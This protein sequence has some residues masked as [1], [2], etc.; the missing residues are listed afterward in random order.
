MHSSPV[1]PE[2][3]VVELARVRPAEHHCAILQKSLRSP[4]QQPILCQSARR[5]REARA[6]MPPWE[7]SRLWAAMCYN[8]VQNH[9]SVPNVGQINVSHDH[10]HHHAHRSS[11]FYR[12]VRG[13]ALSSP[14]N[15]VVRETIVERQVYF[16][17][18]DRKWTCHL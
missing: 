14:V 13:L 15:A 18:S 16:Q 3:T 5:E 7:E 12:C 6:E 9:M 2:Q 4:S 17:S 11:D 1:R 8:V 10:H